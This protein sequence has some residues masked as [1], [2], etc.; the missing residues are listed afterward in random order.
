MYLTSEENSPTIFEVARL[1]GDENRAARALGKLVEGILPMGWPVFEKCKLKGA[2]LNSEKIV[3]TIFEV[4]ESIADNAWA[5]R[6]LLNLMKH[7]L[8]VVLPV[9]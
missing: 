4:A 7:S 9:F 1:I 3:P 6:A 2:S 8:P 5:I